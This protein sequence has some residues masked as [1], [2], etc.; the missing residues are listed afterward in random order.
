MLRSACSLLFAAAVAAWPATGQEADVVF[1]SDV[2][3]VRVDAQVL[4]RD[5]RA[6]TGLT[7]EDFVLTEE[8]KA[9]P[10]RHF[11]NEDMPVDIVLLLD[12]SGS[13]RSHVERIAS[14]AHTALQVLRERDRVAIMVFDRTS[15][16]R[17]PFRSSQED[18]EA[19]LEGV[20]R[21][22]TFDG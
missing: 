15:R 6:V 12:V 19:G 21:Q 1:R 16:L 4:D 20:L 14:A 18:V 10:I 7:A 13:M 17:L 2:S 22:E 3:L 11:A 8:G 9:Q 5:R